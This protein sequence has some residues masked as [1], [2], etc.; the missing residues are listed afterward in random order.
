MI[1]LPRIAHVI[2]PLSWRGG[3]QQAIY[4]YEELAKLGVYQLILCAKGS[5]TEKYCES[6]G[7]RFR[8]FKKRLN[9]DPF[10]ARSI[11][12]VCR[13]EKID[14]VHPHDSGAHTLC[15]LAADLFSNSCP[16]VLHRRVD[17]PISSSWFSRYKYN[18]SSIKKIIC[19]SEA[20]KEILQKDI[21]NKGLLGVVYD[22]IDVDAFDDPGGGRLRSEFHL[23]PTIPIVANIAALTQQK[24]YF[25]FIDTVEILEKDGVK[26]AWFAFGEGAQRE[27]LE[28][29]SMEKGLQEKIRFAGFRKD[30]RTIIPEIDVLLFSSETEGLGTTIL[31]CFA[32][33]VA[34]VS[35]DAG[36]IPEIMIHQQT[37]WMGKV[38]DPESLAEGV[39]IAL[40]QPETKKEW[41]KGAKKRVQLFRRSLTAKKTL[42]IYQEIKASE[43]N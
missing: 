40:T 3:E 19:V 25:T 38:K 13:E 33:G 23:D 26:A 42:D 27:A 37:G 5:A 16:L 2:S 32:A 15:I 7:L 8:S 18:H 41:I 10:F 17:F 4:L 36:G 22:G 11:G 28:A 24:D 31:D 21:R 34:V 30:I 20:V 35:T 6:H 29:Y 9:I 1:E 12:R 39:K 43:K 14:I